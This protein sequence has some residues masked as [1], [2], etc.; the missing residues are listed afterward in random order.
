[1]I[2]HADFAYHANWH[3]A[4]KTAKEVWTAP[5]DLPE[6]YRSQKEASFEFDE[7]MHAY[8]IDQSDAR[9]AQRLRRAAQPHACGFVTAVPSD[10]D[11]KD[12]LLRPR[13]F[14]IAIAYRLGIYVVDKEISCSL[15]KQII[16]K[17]GDH[18]TAAQRMEIQLFAITEFVTWLEILRMMECCHLYWKRKA[19][20]VTPLAVALEMSLLLAGL[21]GKV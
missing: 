10:E 4:Q 9:G 5:P 6:K 7:K 17:F 16:D 11:G 21:K 14:Q 19:F 20:S 2:E 3:E 1:M 13:Q 15:C 18:A 8:L 12:T